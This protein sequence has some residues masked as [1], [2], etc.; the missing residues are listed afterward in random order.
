MPL[1]PELLARGP[2]NPSQVEIRW[3]PD[4]FEADAGKEAEADLVLNGL[5]ERGSPSHD[6]LAARLVSY[7]A[8]DGVLRLELQPIRWALRLV[9]DADSSISA[10]CIVRAVDG[11]WLAGHRAD[12][13]ASWAG[14]WALGAG[15]SVEVD[16]NPADT[17]ARELEEEW[18]VRPDR[19][20]IEALV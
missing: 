9:S 11:S 1:K 14:R 10:L 7:E 15:G 5:R 4:P 2:W 18:S 12:W 16:E 8:T 19:L 3:R 20:Q 13:V 6:G 17:L